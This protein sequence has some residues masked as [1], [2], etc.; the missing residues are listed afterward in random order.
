TSNDDLKAAQK[1][2]DTA[3]V[4]ILD[5]L[6]DTLA[7]KVCDLSAYSMWQALEHM[8]NTETTCSLITKLRGLLLHSMGSDHEDPVEYWI[9]S[10]AKWHQFP[11]LDLNLREV[12]PL[13]VLG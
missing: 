9:S 1:I 13:I 8:F 4:L 11:K 3:I 7:E 12:A 6:E 10:I 5:S 2:N